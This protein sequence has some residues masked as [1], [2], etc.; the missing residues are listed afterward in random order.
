MVTFIFCTG[1]SSVTSSVSFLCEAHNYI[2]KTFEC[3]V[4]QNF[5]AIDEDENVVYHYKLKALKHESDIYIEID[6][7]SRTGGYF[8]ALSGLDH[9]WILGDR[10]S[11]VRWKEHRG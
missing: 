7:F 11:Q 6:L 8:Y 3:C 9:F 2:H 5:Q 4:S 10:D 1:Q